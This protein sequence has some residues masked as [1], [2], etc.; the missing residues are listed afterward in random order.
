MN[1][2]LAQTITVGIHQPLRR[3]ERVVL[4]RGFENDVND[5]TAVTPK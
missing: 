3:A 2:E 4:S 5:S 1:H